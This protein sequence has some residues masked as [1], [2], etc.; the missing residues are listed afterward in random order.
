[1][2]TAIIA[3]QASPL[4]LSPGAAQPGCAPRANERCQTSL[5]PDQMFATAQKLAEADHEDQ[6]IELLKALTRDRNPDFRAEARVRLAHLLLKRGDRIGALVWLRQL[7]DEKP[8]A[9]AVRLE[10]ASLLAQT[11]DTVGAR[12][13]LR[14]IQA[15]S[16]PPNVAVAVNRYV[17]ALRSRKPLG[18]SLELA[19]APDSNINRATS[20]TTLD[21]VIAP[22]NLSRDARERSGTGLKEASQG[23][24]RLDVGKDITLVPRLSSQ[25]TLY[26]ASQFNDISGSAQVGVEYRSAADRLTPSAGYTWR[27]YGGQIYARTQSVN[28][29]WLHPAGRRA[30]LD[31]SASV[32][33]VRYKGSR[34]QNGMIYT[35]AVTYERALTVRSGASVTLSANRQTAEDA[36]YATKSGAFS[37]VYWHD[38]GRITLFAS[39]TAAR[40]TADARLFI[41]PDRRADWYVRGGA[42]AIWRKVH[43]AG[44]SPLF[45][46]GYERNWS[47]VRIYDF[48][49][50]STEFGITRGF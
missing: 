5:T 8:D 31:A 22:L 40:L 14:Q 18:G 19:L 21:T 20:A 41:F 28:F 6:A 12:R 43:V 17:E 4:A 39:A 48:R 9:A 1:M 32:N 35:A 34:L 24:M 2:L 23:Y 25:A 37:S 42:G 7:L 30:Q 29:D 49:R 27:W 15:G 11:G 33:R 26:R 13:A 44:F 50:F 16:L 46:F 38:A 45:R 3:I 36:G 10:Y 47:T